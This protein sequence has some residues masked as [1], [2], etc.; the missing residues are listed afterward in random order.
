MLLPCTQ[1]PVE[2]GIEKRPSPNITHNA[3]HA[4]DLP[5]QCSKCDT[6]YILKTGKTVRLRLDADGLTDS[7]G[8]RRIDRSVAMRVGVASR[9]SGS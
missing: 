7:D 6:K 2:Q 9:R 4:I 1:Q 3:S 5:V 8:A